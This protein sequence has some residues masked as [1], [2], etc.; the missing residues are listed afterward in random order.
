[1]PNEVR[2]RQYRTRFEY[3]NDARLWA[4]EGW[5]VA[6]VV[7]EQQRVGCLRILFTG[8]LS[9]VW[10]PPSRLLVTYSRD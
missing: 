2:V 10:K 8:P 3:E 6:S 7:Q 4:A 1:M 9:L 5:R